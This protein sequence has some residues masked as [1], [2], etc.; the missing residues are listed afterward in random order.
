MRS[1]VIFG[2]QGAAPAGGYTEHVTVDGVRLP[3][4]IVRTPPPA[5]AS[6]A[7]EHAQAVLVQVRALSC[8]FRDRGFFQVMKG[9]AGGRFSS[10]GS[11]FAGEVVA[12]GAEVRELRVGDRVMP[13]HHYTGG[14]VDG[15]GVREGVCTNQAS[16]E[17][18]VVPECK[19]IRL[20]PAMPFVEAAAFSL[21]AQTAYSMVRRLDVRPGERAL[22]TS[23]ASN[24]SHFLIHALRGRGAE[25]TAST[26]SER[27]HARLETLGVSRVLTADR[28]LAE[29]GE[30][31]H[32]LDPF[33]D[34]HLARA[35]TLLRPFGKYI[36][37]GLAA[38][39]AELAQQRGDV[40]LDATRILGAAIVKNLSII[41][42]CIGLR[43][44]LE[45]AL[46]DYNAGLWA[47]VLDSTY[48]G[49]DVSAFLDRSFNDR[50][51]FGKV[52]F[53]YDS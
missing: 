34:L 9:V 6:H 3:C 12:V 2:A 35:V 45:R 24:T 27:F 36:T 8:N 26:S 20:P 33:F 13:N 31:H 7:P 49:D 53:R 42:N 41:G 16:R 19:L 51:R 14:Q 17:L 25:V 28:L 37:C 11:E 47:P 15:S 23:A 39:N 18:Q 40:D 46:E 48:A 43:A 32:V 30:F 38:Q 10:L 29:G 52:V 4:A 21:G 44:D 22:V 1:L 5:F 50:S